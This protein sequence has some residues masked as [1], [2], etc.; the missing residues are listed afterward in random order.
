MGS[1]PSPTKLSWPL[2]PP[3]KRTRGIDLEAASASAL[4]DDHVPHK[5]LKPQ[6][7]F[8]FLHRS[9]VWAALHHYRSSVSELLDASSGGIPCMFY[10]HRQ[11]SHL[12]NMLQEVMARRRSGG[13]PLISYDHVSILVDK[14]HLSDGDDAGEEDEESDSSLEVVLGTSLNTTLEQLE[15]DLFGTPGQ[16]R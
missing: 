9:S 7:L 4:L 11:F 16:P 1:K 14:I 3:K 6:Q 8:L 2:S 10:F 12:R 13:R 15:A 5:F